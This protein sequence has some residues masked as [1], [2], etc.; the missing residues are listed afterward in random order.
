MLCYVMLCYVMLCCIELLNL[1]ECELTYLYMSYLYI[2]HWTTSELTTTFNWMLDGFIHF[3]LFNFLFFFFFFL[4]SF[5]S[6]LFDFCFDLD[7]LTSVFSLFLDG[8]ILFKKNIIT[9]LLLADLNQKVCKGANDL[10]NDRV[11]FYQL[12]FELI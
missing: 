8:K 6:K 4:N 10:T 12:I 2:E 11:P 5:F 1:P 7:F 9:K 3:I